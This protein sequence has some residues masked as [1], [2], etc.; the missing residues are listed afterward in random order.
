MN[1]YPLNIG[2]IA[3]TRV[4]ESQG[5]LL[6][7]EEIFPD[8]TVDVLQQGSRWLM[9]EFYDAASNKLVIAVQSFLIQLDGLTILVDSCVGDRKQRAR[10]EFHDQSWNWLNQL[11][12][13]GVAPEDVDM[14]ICS[15][16]HVDHVGWNTRLANGRWVPTFP[17]ARYVFSREEL[18]FWRSSEGRSALARTGDYIGDS[19]LPVLDAQQADLV[20]MDHV[21][22]EK[23]RLAPAPGHTPGHVMVHLEDANTHAILSG[24][25]MH[26]PLQVQFPH[27]STR[28]CADQGAARQTRQR[29]LCQMADTQTLVLPAHFPAPTA[30]RI[31]REAEGYGFCFCG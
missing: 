15:H 30:G 31:T 8:Y 11:S 4:V 22:H 14:V 7:P 20:T 12:N 28:Y 19:V 13:A 2:S 3:L 21:L 23:L 16:L 25:T 24:D 9:P 27:W 29:F 18:A 17:N 1:A 26:H 6:T 5:P 10:G